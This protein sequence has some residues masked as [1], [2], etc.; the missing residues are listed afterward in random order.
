[1]TYETTPATG[2]NQQIACLEISATTCIIPVNVTEHPPGTQFL[3]GLTANTIHWSSS[4]AHITVKTAIE[5]M[6]IFAG[7]SLFNGLNMISEVDLNLLLF[8]SHCKFSFVM[9]QPWQPF[10]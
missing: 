5:G 2:L 8:G 7:M 3:V 9:V 1:M 6:T 4:M 10:L